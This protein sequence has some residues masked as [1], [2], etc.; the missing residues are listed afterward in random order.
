[1]ALVDGIVE[2]IRKEMAVPIRVL[3][4]GGF[5]NLIAPESESIERIDEFLTLDGLRILYD[6]NQS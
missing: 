2:R 4:T 6:R 1:M 3:A 5:A